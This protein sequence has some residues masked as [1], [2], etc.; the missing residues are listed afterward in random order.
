[1]FEMAKL[2]RFKEKFDFYMVGYMK[3]KQIVFTRTFAAVII[4]IILVTFPSTYEVSAQE[5]L[6]SQTKQGIVEIYSGFYAKDGVFH[7][8]KHASGFLVNNQGGQAYIVTVCDALKST[9]KEKKKYCKKNQLSYEE[10]TLRDSIQVVIKGDI[11]TEAAVLIESE[12]ENYSILQVKDTISKKTAV[13]FGSNKDLAIGDNIYAMGFDKDAGKNDEDRNRLTEFS[14]LDV[15]IE[16]GNIQDAGANK[17]G[18]LYLQHSARITEGNTGGPLL[19]EN[20]YVVGLNNAVLNAKGSTAYYSL[21]V[22]TIREILDNFGIAYLSSDKIEA[23]HTL[24]RLLKKSKKLLEDEEYKEESKKLLQDAVNEAEKLALDENTDLSMV[25]EIS[26]QLI[27]NSGLL[28]RKMTMTQKIILAL[29]VA[30]ACLGAGLIVL[31]IRKRKNRQ[32]EQEKN[33]KK[34]DADAQVHE[35]RQDSMK[36]DDWRRLQPVPDR[37]AVRGGTEEAALMD[38]QAACG[39]AQEAPTDRREADGTAEE[40]MLLGS[41]VVQ[42]RSEQYKRTFDREEE[43]E[44][45]SATQIGSMDKSSVPCLQYV[46]PKSDMPQRI[47]VHMSENGRFTI[48]RFDVVVGRPQS[49]FEFEKNT[50]GVSRHHAVIEKQGRKYAICDLQSSAGTYVNENKINPG[51]SVVLQDDDRVSFGYDGADYIWKDM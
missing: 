50:K 24:N 35:C 43:K 21:P 26:K 44:W 29:V 3:K 10:N 45:D 40:T 48:G 38:R 28:E 42:S 18:V 34:Y 51:G 23:F 36:K 12:K 25:D 37:Q 27:E 1:M 14:A 31:V 16:A 15:T 2:G 30:V 49:D 4:C 47:D 11:M 33:N 9:E 22:D 39:D 6:V 19:N 5:D 46:G 8:L 17:S 20:G 32:M 7:Q 13:W 41:F